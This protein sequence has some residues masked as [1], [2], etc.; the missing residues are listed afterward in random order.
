MNLLGVGKDAGTIDVPGPG[1]LD[2]KFL[3]DPSRPGREHQNPVPQT[4]GFPH[5]M[6]HKKHGLAGLR[7]NLLKFFMEKVPGLGVE[8]RKRLIHEQC[9]RVQRQ[10]PGERNP[11]LH[12]PRKLMEMGPLESSQ[13]HQIQ[14]SPGNFT[15]LFGFHPP[16]QAE[17][18]IAKHIEPGEKSRLLK[19]DHP[20]AARP[21]HHFPIF[22][23]P[24]FAGLLEA[25]NNI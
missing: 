23:D 20:I 19:D 6:G 22:Q 7:P 9:R 1:E 16:H 15:A 18:D 5:V 24:A 2:L 12:P 17:F 10:S 25:R 13:M 21:R 11:A 8:R 4:D 3:F 14:E